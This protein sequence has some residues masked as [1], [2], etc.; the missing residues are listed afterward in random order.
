MDD[1]NPTEVTTGAIV[2]VTVTLIRRDM[3][4]LFGDE[5]IEDKNIVNEN[6]ADIGDTKDGSDAESEHHSVKRPVWQ[7]QRKFAGK[8][9]NKK[10]KQKS[11][12]KHKTEESP[13]PVKAKTAK[14][15]KPKD[16]DSDLS[17]SSTSEINESNNGSEDEGK[18]GNAEDE[19]A[20]D[21][22]N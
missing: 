3:S 4:S 2:T 14:E 7:K 8:K 19:V 9:T 10:V 16:D 22:V 6:N 18:N 1:E 20:E 11:T 5:S 21:Q 12:V 17:D 15:E 13:A